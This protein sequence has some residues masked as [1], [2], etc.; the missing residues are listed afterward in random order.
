ML[1]EA[2]LDLCQGHAMCEMEAPGIFAVPKKGK[3]T[4]L[5]PAP[6]ESSRAEAEAAVRYCPTQAL[7]ITA[8]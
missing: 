5:E 2:D 4:I 1:I 3:V 8:G 6:P 7:K